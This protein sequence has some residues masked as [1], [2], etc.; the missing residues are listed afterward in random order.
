M[1]N[2]TAPGL[3]TIGLLLL[4]LV[5]LLL[6]SGC[7]TYETRGAHTAELVWQGM[8]AVDT[9]Q[10]VTIARSPTCWHEADRLAAGVYGS[11]NPAPSRVLATNALLA[12][13]HYELG[14][15]LD[16]RTEA[17]GREDSGIGWYVARGAF[18]TFSFLGTGLAVTNNSTRGIGLA[19]SKVCP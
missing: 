11:Q 14:A 18:Y 13:G 3:S 8:N 5:I 10:T 9:A 1:K 6:L 2:F 7:A 4:V 16:R 12:W 15:W 19:T 17:E